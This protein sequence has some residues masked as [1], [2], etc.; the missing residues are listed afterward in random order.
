MGNRGCLHDP[1]GQI[2]RQHIGTRWIICLLEFKG[3][4]RAVMTPDR[5][6]ELFFLDEATALSA[7]HRPCAECHR[8]RFELFRS[9]WAEA[10]PKLAGTSRPSAAALDAALHR[11]RTATGR[12]AERMCA[13]LDGLPAGTFVTP[14]AR[15]AYLVLDSR[16]LRW[17]PAG[18][19][20]SV[21]AHIQFPARVLTPPSVVGTLA[22]GYPVDIHPSANQ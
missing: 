19:E 22:A 1:S 2:V 10:N 13:S 9:L 14:D 12:S 20:P 5:Y 15:S 21:P 7:G 4:R 11:E 17:T 8:Q 6:T 16:V 3:R 18:Y